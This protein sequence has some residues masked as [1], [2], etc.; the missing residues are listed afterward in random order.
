[1]NLFAPELGKLPIRSDYRV[2]LFPDQPVV[3]QPA[4]LGMVQQDFSLSAPLRQSAADEWAASV[5]IRNQEF[6][7]GAVLPDTGDPFPDALWNVRIGT[8]YRH[9]FDSGWIGALTVTVG[10]PSDRP[11][12]SAAELD[13]SATTVL[14][15]PSRDRDAWIFFLNYGNNR[16]FLPHIPIPGF[17]Y[18]YQPSDQLTAVVTTGFVSLE[19]RPVEKLT[20]TASYV[21]VRTVDV[22]ATYQIFRPVR[23][24]VGFDWTNERYLRAGRLDRDDRL[25]YYEKRVRAGAII[26]L[27]RQLFVDITVGYSFDRFYFEG[28]DYGDRNRIDVEDGPFGAVR[29]GTRF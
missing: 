21:A 23:L 22:R 7:T 17:G 25:F 16:E 14:R 20:L 4:E 12:A 28:E 3:G 10:S 24:W 13:V 8:S 11:F 1:M 15:V 5:R 26:G 27:A 18:S 9:R 2:T 19:Y 29:I 6:A